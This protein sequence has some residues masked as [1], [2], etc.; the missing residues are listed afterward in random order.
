MLCKMFTLKIDRSKNAFIFTVLNKN[1]TYF[2]Q[3]IT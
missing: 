3:H 1:Y 2:R